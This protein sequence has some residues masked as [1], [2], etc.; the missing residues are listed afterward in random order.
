[1]IAYLR[2]EYGRARE[3]ETPE[4]LER[5]E[6]RGH[7]ALWPG[8]RDD[9]SAAEFVRYNRAGEGEAEATLEEIRERY[10]APAEAT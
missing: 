8:A 5:C 9:D 7:S 4:R 1:M 2:D 10:R 6:Q 3:H